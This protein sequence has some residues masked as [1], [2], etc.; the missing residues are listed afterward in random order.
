MSHEPEV[1]EPPP[2][3]AVEVRTQREVAEFFGVQPLQV[4]R[5]KKAGCPE[6]VSAPYDLG[7]IKKWREKRA[8][9]QTT[10]RPP[11]GLTPE[12]LAEAKERKLTADADKVELEVKL[13][14]RQ[15]EILEHNWVSRETVDAEVR[16]K[17]A[18]V[19]AALML[20][21]PSYSRETVAT[22]KLSEH[23][24]IWER[25]VDETLDLLSSEN[26]WGELE[27]R[28]RR[29]KTGATLTRGRGRPKGSKNKK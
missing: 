25:A 11:K 17:F 26:F 21:P 14:R 18:A 12:T 5:W 19:R 10:G 8:S 9:E 13:K 24:A 1:V 22:S 23:E 16:D 6:L 15:L 4:K 27:K 3:P 2:I 28:Q 29:H 20:M 7:E